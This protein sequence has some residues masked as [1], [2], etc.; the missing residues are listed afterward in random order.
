MDFKRGSASSRPIIEM[1]IP[2]S[3]DSSISPPGKHVALLFVQYTP[4]KPHVGDAQPRGHPP[5]C[6]LYRRAL[7]IRTVENLL[8]GRYSV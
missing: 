7:G 2:S 3:V 6:R 5:H 4:Y 1:A 8:Q